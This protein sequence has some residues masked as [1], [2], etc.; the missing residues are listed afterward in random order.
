MTDIDS[1]VSAGVDKALEARV[2]RQRDLASV[3][4]PRPI[5]LLDQLNGHARLNAWFKRQTAPRFPD[6]FALYDFILANELGNAP[7]DYLEFGV[8]EGRVMKR[9]S[10]IATDPATRFFGFDT[11]E[12][13]PTDWSGPLGKGHFD[14]S[15]SLPD[16]QD[17]RVQF[18]KGLF[19][20]TLVGFLSTF[21][22]RSRLVIHNDSDLYS[23]TLYTL[24][25]LD[26]IIEP[27]TLIIFDEFPSPMHEYRAWTDYCAAFMRRATLVAS[28]G[29]YAEQAVFRFD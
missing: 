12:G 15:G 29:P 3:V 8:F 7:I 4:Y 28:S 24:A 16:I 11:F 20:E 17:D 9:W 5:G 10:T 27:G 1:S 6:R 13:L 18:I 21:E 19:Q 26:D 25:K 23:S 2:R 14:V 22:K